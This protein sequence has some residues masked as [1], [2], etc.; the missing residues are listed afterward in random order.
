M[1]ER[2]FNQLR[3]NHQDLELED[4]FDYD[5]SSMFIT[6][7]PLEMWNYFNTENHRTNNSFKNY[8]RILNSYFNSKAKIIKL[9]NILVVDEELIFKEYSEKYVMDIY[10]REEELVPYYLS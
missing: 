7:F 4:L 1:V 10:P 8:N 3:I 5:E 9:I 6:K 2:V